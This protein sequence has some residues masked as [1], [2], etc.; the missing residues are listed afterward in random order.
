MTRS[1]FI[2]KGKSKTVMTQK[3][4]RTAKLDIRI[5]PELKLELLLA[6]QIAQVT[7]TEWVERAVVCA[8]RRKPPP[9]A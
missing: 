3:P 2:S 7:V 4:L 6:A 1:L 8:M 5:T 9:G